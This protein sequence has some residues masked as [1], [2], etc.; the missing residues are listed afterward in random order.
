M[1]TEKANKYKEL[2]GHKGNKEYDEWFLR[3]R[4]NEMPN[5]TKTNTNTN[6]N[7]HNN[8]NNNHQNNSF[9]KKKKTKRKTGYRKKKKNMKTHRRK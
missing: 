9:T 4:P 1:R 6:N 2:K 3:Y 7:N 5:F 8:S